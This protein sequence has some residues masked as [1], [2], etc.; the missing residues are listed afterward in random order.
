MRY[1]GASGTVPARLLYAPRAL[2][3]LNRHGLEQ[4]IRDDRRL[5]QKFVDTMQMRRGTFEGCE[6]WR[7]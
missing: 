7:A 4:A 2:F 3:S 5:V 1:A 6:M